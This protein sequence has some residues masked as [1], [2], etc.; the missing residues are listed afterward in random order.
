ME[1]SDHCVFLICRLPAPEIG[2]GYAFSLKHASNDLVRL[3]KLTEDDDLVFGM[4]LFEI[5]H[6]LFDDSNFCGRNERLWVSK[7][8]GCE[9]GRVLFIWLRLS[10]IDI[11]AQFLAS[12]WF[13]EILFGDRN[14]PR[15]Q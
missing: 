4:V 6:Q 9:P 1:V 3:K 10:S 14:G 12:F 8:G 7:I 2:E 13:S 15:S 5:K 11:I